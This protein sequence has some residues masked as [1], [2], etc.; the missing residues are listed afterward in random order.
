MDQTT[1]EVRPGFALGRLLSTPGALAALVE[2]G[3]DGR[4]FLKRHY[5][6]DWGD[7]DPEDKKANDR[8]LMRGERI[9]SAYRLSTGQKL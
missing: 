4:T 9:L 6:G 7:L 2:A 8:A 5:S 1:G 3:Q